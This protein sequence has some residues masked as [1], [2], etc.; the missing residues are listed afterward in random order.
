MGKVIIGELLITPSHSRETASRPS[1]PLT[2]VYC[3]LL[4][5]VVGLRG[6]GEVWRRK[7]PPRT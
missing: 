7:I 5:R 2:T 6:R 3:H 1:N 4:N